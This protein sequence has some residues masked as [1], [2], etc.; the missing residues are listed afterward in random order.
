MAGIRS[1]RGERFLRARQRAFGVA[2]PVRRHGIGFER[3]RGVPGA[4]R[5]QRG[6][7]RGLGD[8][9]R[10]GDAPLHEQ[11][12]RLEGE[13]TGDHRALSRGACED[14][15]ASE[16]I[17]RVVDALEA[18]CCR[19]DALDEVDALDEPLVGQHA[20]ARSA[21]SSRSASASLTLPSEQFE[22]LLSIAATKVVSWSTPLP[23][24]TAWA[25]RARLRELAT[26]VVVERDLDQERSAPRGC[27]RL[28]RLQCCT[29]SSRDSSGPPVRRFALAILTISSARATGSS[30]GNSASDCSSAPIDASYAPADGERRRRLVEQVEAPAVVGIRRQEPQRGEQP[31]AGGERRVRRNFVRA[32]HEHRDRVL[33]TEPRRPLDVMSEHACR[34]MDAGECLRRPLVRAELPRAR[35][36][37]VDGTADDRVSEAKVPG[38]L[39]GADEVGREQLVERDL[40]RRL[41]QFGD[42]RDE[43]R[44][45][46]LARD[47]GRVRRSPGVRRQ[48]RELGADRSRDRR[49]WRPSLA[50]VFDRQRTAGCGGVAG[51]HQLFEVEGIPAALVVEEGAELRVEGGVH[52]RLRLLFGERLRARA[53]PPTPRAPVRRAR[54]GRRAGSRYANAPITGATEP[55]EHVRDHLDRA[56]RRPIARRRG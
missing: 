40:H 6:V 27:S 30:S 28:E 55:T 25:K 44:H 9:Q 37:V 16:V 39:G 14:E 38:R 42:E 15:A 24:S 19:R 49:R 41:R 54:R 5:Q 48:G 7:D 52:Q 2:R 29:K 13:P 18:E 12:E 53:E 32:F 51:P 33:V 43:A 1:A 36:A 31:A 56:R 3:V 8:L 46:R 17:E 11:R 20:R 21:P 23:T 50:G 22:R 35:R 26:P 4:A 34:S 10:I 45:E 47:R